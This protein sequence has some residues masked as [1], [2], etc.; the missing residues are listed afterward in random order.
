MTS[1]S[2]VNRRLAMVLPPV[3]TVF[4]VFQGIFYGCFEK[5]CRGKETFLKHLHILLEPVTSVIVQVDGACGLLVELLYHFLKVVV[6]V[7]LFYG[8]SQGSMPHF[9]KGLLEV[10]LNMVQV[11]L[12]LEV[13]LTD[14]T[15]VEH[16][17]YGMLSCLETCFLFCNDGL[18]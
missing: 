10:N 17:L 2:S 7:I 12:V 8:G 13:F 16:L 4:L 6:D 3:Q 15:E 1:M 5:Q 9:I 11:L 18:C 14:N